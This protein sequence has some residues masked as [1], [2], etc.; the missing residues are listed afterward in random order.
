MPD[1]KTADDERGRITYST[2]MEHRALAGM[3]VPYLATLGLLQ[4]DTQKM[5]FYV[6]IFMVRALHER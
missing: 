2:A 3:V 4:K 1:P 5:K 6:L